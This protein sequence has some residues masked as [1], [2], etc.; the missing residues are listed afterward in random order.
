MNKR[1]LVV[2]GAEN[3]SKNKENK[4]EEMFNLTL[5]SKQNYANKQNYDFLIIRSFG[6]DK[7]NKLQRTDNHLG[8]LRVIRCLEMLEYYDI[9]MWIDGDSIITNQN[10]NINDFNL[11]DDHCFYASWDWMHKTPYFNGHYFHAFSL[12]NFI[13]KNGK[14]LK[15]FT[16]TFLNSAKYFPDEQ[17]CLNML[18]A[19]TPLKNMIKILDHN[20]LGGVPEE[21]QNFSVW[22][23]RPKLISPWNKN[24][25]L[26]HFTGISNEQRIELM[27][28]KF[29]NYL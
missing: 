22:K 27:K 17:Y 16:D 12:G 19:K 4:I 21:V 6:I 11:D 18:Y 25:F 2:T 26:C 20:F 9:V 13:I 15:E 23:D 1:V 3:I 7:E 29:N 24:N 14:T 28:N 5:P 10:L 8:F